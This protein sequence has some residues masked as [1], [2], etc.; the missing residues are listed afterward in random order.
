MIPIFKGIV[1][2]GK[3]ELT[4]RKAFNI[5]LSSLKGEVEVIVRKRI[6]RR[7]IKQNKLYWAYLDLIEKETGNSAEDL[8]EV[9]KRD[10]LESR[11]KEILGKKEKLSGTTTTLSTHEFANYLK[12]IEQRTNVLIP[13]WNKVDI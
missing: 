6:K 10:Y 7:N 2:N 3:L 1:E 9:F 13:D 12:K 8:H 5:Y 4:E 11:L